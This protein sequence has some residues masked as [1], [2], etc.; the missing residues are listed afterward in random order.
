LKDLA[1]QNNAY[2]AVGLMQAAPD[3]ARIIDLVIVLQTDPADPVAKKEAI[4]VHDAG[5]Q[6]SRGGL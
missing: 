1:S 2:A 5:V 6:R 3:L 4:R